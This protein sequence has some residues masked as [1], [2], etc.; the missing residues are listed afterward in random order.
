LSPDR[1]ISIDEAAALRALDAVERHAG[2]LFAELRVVLGEA[3]HAARNGSQDGWTEVGLLADQTYSW[4]PD[5]GGLERYDPFVVYERGDLNLALAHNTQPVVVKDRPRKQI[6]VFHL[7]APR[8]SKRP[9]VPFVAADDYDETGELVAIIR[10]KGPNGRKMFG[11]GDALPRE[12]ERVRLDRFGNRITG[13]Y[14]K[15]CVVATEEDPV[16]ML[17]HGAAQIRLREVAKSSHY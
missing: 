8:G 11:P 15:F 17:N 4:P 7:R 6:W 12:Y 10:G 14:D 1:R 13:H 16:T 2:A 3:G 5:A 9:I